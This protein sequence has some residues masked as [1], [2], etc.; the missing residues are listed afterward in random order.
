LSRIT[1]KVAAIVAE[2]SNNT[3]PCNSQTGLKS[4]T[5]L[6]TFCPELAHART[7]HKSA[8]N[9]S[10]LQNNH[11]IGPTQNKATKQSNG[12]ATPIRMAIA[13]G[14]PPEAPVPSTS[15]MQKMSFAYLHI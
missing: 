1:T 11:D 2:K 12:L 10:K 15:K 8:T 3:Q 7:E 5:L 4:V 14:H 13:H 9:L 6:S